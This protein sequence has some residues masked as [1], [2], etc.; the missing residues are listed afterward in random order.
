MIFPEGW[1]QMLCFL[2]HSSGTF[3]RSTVERIKILTVLMVSLLWKK[4]GWKPERKWQVALLRKDNL[5]FDLSLNWA[6]FRRHRI[7]TCS[8]REVKESKNV[9]QQASWKIE[10]SLNIQCIF[11]IGTLSP[12][13]ICSLSTLARQH[14]VF[15]S[16]S[17][18]SRNSSQLSSFFCFP[19][20]WCLLWNASSF[21]LHHITQ[22]CHIKAA[23]ETSSLGSAGGTMLCG[24]KD[25]CFLASALP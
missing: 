20:S 18:Y 19:V 21:A 6:C 2:W 4:M 8:H 25:E 17:V 9:I 22:W 16:S 14:G 15:G 11:S 7:D 3:N 13:R 5:S 1:H 24:P 23:A 12:V 10:C